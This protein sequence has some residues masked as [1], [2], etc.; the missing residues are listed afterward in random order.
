MDIIDNQTTTLKSDLSKTLRKDSRVSIAA[1]CFSMYAYRELKKELEGIAELRFVFTSPSFVRDSQQ[2][3]QKREFYIPKRDREHSLYGTE[4]EIK[5]RNEMTQRA[6]ARECAEWVRSKV[7]FK[8]NVSGENIPHSIIVSHGEESVAYTPVPGFTT[9]DLGCERGNNLYTIITRFPDASALIEKFDAVWNDSERLKDVTDEV[10]DCIRAAYD[11]N[12]PELIYFIALY[13]IFSEFLEDISEDVLPN[14]ATG[15]RQSKIWNMLY[16]FQK[17]AALAIINKL[18]KY[19][20]CIL[21]DSVGL[22]KT[23]TALSVI[24]YYENRN[25]SVLVLCPKKLADNWNTYKDNYVNNPIA[26]DRLGY[27][28][29]FHSDLSRTKGFSNGTDLSRL[30]WSNYDLIVID[31][32][33]NFRNGAAS[34]TSTRENRYERLLNQAIR[35]GVKTKV[36]MLSATPVNNRFADLEHQIALAYEG[37]PE[38]INEKLNISKDIKSVFKQAQRAFNTWSELP[39]ERRTTQSLLGML[40][41]D[42]FQILDSVT[43]A[44]SRKHIRNSPDADKI[45]QFPQRMKPESHQPGLTDLESAATYNKI[46]EELLKLNLHVYI[47]SFYIHQSRLAKY[48]IDPEEHAGLTQAGREIG[49]QRLMATNMLKRLESSVHSFRLT[50]E[51]I[52]SKIQG[53]IDLIDK[54]EA[55]LEAPMLVAAEVA[56]SFYGLDEDEDEELYSVGKG[57]NI[58]LVDMDWES[59]R[60]QMQEDAKVLDTM[61]CMVESITPEHDS[62]LQTLKNLIINKQEKPLNPGNK[63]ILVFSAFSDTV[64]YLY[65]ELAPFFQREH[66]VDS[67]LITGRGDG[68]ST[69]QKLSPSLNNIL[70]CFSPVSKERAVLMPDC[71]AE[72]DILFATDCVSEGQNLQDCDYVVNY[73]IHWNP[74]RIIQRFGR[75]DRIG[76]KNARIQLVNFWPDMDLDEYIHLKTRVQD[77]MKA[78]VL[79]AT[80]DDDPINEEEQGDLEYRKQQL[81][82]LQEEVVDLEDMSEG[83]SITDL[84]L[85]DFRTDL[86]EYVGEHPD[87]E[88][89]PH[90]MHAVVPATDDMPPGCIFILRNVND[91][92]NVD[93]RNLVHPFYMVYVSNAGET[94]CDYLNPKK[95]LDAMRNLCRG[96]DK[97]FAELC[98]AFNKETQDGQDMRATS[99]LLDKA[100]ESIIASKEM[101]DIDSLFRSGGTTA[102]LSPIKGLDDFELICF[103]VV[104]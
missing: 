30:V 72:I 39:V 54:F 102:L 61:I 64:E 101:S 88:R 43:I 90:G 69:V 68:K 92:V 56:D 27:K 13:N 84:G 12:S 34:G 86:L 20:G 10:L 97:L 32:S 35:K 63:K 47:P 99:E 94:V 79:T 2:S 22:G 96:R 66:R 36:L 57:I 55:N 41:F 16:G 62:K 95:L 42:F 37:N 7:V 80:G 40:D 48:N 6:I 3:K 104:R 45:G 51:R 65:R 49:I 76:S 23:F 91:S 44:R 29:L 31:E 74:V 14:E 103:L 52:R 78:T 17:Q 46:F 18:E 73:D 33:H 70:T 11:E 58:E 67:A 93:D 53:F 26:E 4:F 21:A 89:M 71:P 98:R 25:K 59:W 5:L 75:V 15:F 60:D 77:R 100:I 87:V 50:L 83:V 9:V 19:N 85:T 24:K 8:S 82:R 28:V 38:L 1:A 81:K